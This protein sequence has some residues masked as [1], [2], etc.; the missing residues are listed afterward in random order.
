MRSSAPSIRRLRPAAAVLA[1]VAAACALVWAPSGVA[2]PVYRWVDDGGVTHLSSDRP[3][4][5]VQ[6]ERLD[7]GLGRSTG[8]KATRTAAAR[9]AS[10]DRTH[11]ATA[12]RE[13][14]ARRD[15]AVR[16]LQNRECV[17]ALEAMDRLAH[18]GRPVEP[19][20]FRRLQQTAD[21][22]C[23]QDPAV[24]RDQEAMAAKLR[25]AKGDTCVAARNALAEMLEPGRKPS[26]EQL[27]TQQEFIEAHCET[28]VR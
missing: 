27:K 10:G 6:F 3:P 7:V 4:A 18:G 11:L 15:A 21:R 24:R 25:V 28:P 13:Q 22:N 5:G 9:N 1:A 2:S 19:T 23:S 20:E 12:S 26:R 17:V 14:V 8:G 16:E